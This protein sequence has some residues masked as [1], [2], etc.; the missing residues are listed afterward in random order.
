M[1]AQNKGLH[2]RLTPEAERDLENIWRYRATTWSIRQAENYVGDLS[3]TFDL[4]AHSPLIARE[5]AEFTPH[6]RIHRHKSHVIIYRVN[7]DCLDIVRIAHMK[8]NW[9]ALLDE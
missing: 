9:S 8:Q 5:R 1:T 3:D 7:D 2:V 4:L 6:V